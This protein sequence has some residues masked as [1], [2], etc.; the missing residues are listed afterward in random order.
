MEQMQG[1]NNA[2]ECQSCW[3]AENECSNKE[4]WTV[5][6]AAMYEELQ[7]CKTKAGR[8]QDEVTSFRNKSCAK[9]GLLDAFQGLAEAN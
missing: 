5:L 8:H 1:F 9:V 3:M 7:N 2:F 6:M 4:H